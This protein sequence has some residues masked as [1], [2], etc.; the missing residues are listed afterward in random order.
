MS[1]QQIVYILHQVLEAV[2]HCH[3][4]SIVHRDL[5]M[6]N[7]LLAEP[8][9]H[10]DRRVKLADFGFATVLKE[11]ERLTSACGSP[12]YCSPE[13]LAGSSKDS[14]GY[15]LECDVWAVGVIAYSLLCCQYPFDGETDADVVKAVSKGEFDFGDHVKVS[16]DA[17]H[18]VR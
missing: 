2:K 11:H 14:P 16:A 6:E 17:K 1:T 9:Q 10:G 5:K 15:R 12:H 4:R 13:I 7:V 3:D 8:W 18:F